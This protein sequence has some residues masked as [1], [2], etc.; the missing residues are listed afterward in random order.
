MTQLLWIIMHIYCAMENLILYAVRIYILYVVYTP[1]V[2]CAQA[3]GLGNTYMIGI[4]F[5]MHTYW[6]GICSVDLS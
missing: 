6:H 2:G 1:C 5:A 3:V 4:S